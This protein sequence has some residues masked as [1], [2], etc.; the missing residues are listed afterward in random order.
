[1]EL[2][3]ALSYELRGLCGNYRMNVAVMGCMGGTIP[4]SAT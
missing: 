4:G 3:V 1:M 2:D